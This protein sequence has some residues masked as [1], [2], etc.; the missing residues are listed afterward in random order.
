MQDRITFHKYTALGNLSWPKLLI[1]QDTNPFCLCLTLGMQWRHARF[2]SASGHAMSPNC[3]LSRPNY[4]GL[5]ARFPM[6][7]KFG[8]AYPKLYKML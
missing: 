6:L 5:S 1:R 4:F 2:K 3:L 8:I 7:S